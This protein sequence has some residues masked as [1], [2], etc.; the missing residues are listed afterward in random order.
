MAEAPKRI[1][2][3]ICGEQAVLLPW[4]VKSTWRVWEVRA[5]DGKGF[6]YIVCDCHDEGLAEFIAA[7]HNQQRGFDE[8]RCDKCH[9]R[10]GS[11]SGGC[12]RCGGSGLAKDHQPDMTSGKDS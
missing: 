7:E 1:V 12:Y 10:P 5:T 6:D 11:D 8:P 4:S 3:S 2:M 9:G